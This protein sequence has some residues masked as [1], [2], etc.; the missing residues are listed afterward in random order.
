V[1]DWLN[2]S[3]VDPDVIKPGAGKIAERYEQFMGELP[4]LCKE[5][6]LDTDELTFN[7]FTTILVEWLVYNEW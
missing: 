6:H 1:R 2:S 3:P 7:D 5:L 4:D